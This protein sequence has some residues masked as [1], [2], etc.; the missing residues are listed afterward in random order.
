YKYNSQ[1]PVIPNVLRKSKNSYAKFFLLPLKEEAMNHSRQ[2]L[3]AIFYYNIR[4]NIVKKRC[5]F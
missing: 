3:S 1:Q 4:K 5:Y 2:N